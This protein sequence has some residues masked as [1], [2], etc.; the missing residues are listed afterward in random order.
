MRP[1]RKAGP[2]DQQLRLRILTSDCWP[3]G[4]DQL[5][6]T[7]PETGRNL[8]LR[9]GPYGPYLQL[10]AAA[11]GSEKARN[12][13]LPPAAAT[14]GMTLQVRR[15]QARVIKGAKWSCNYPT[16]VGAGLVMGA[17]QRGHAS[18]CRQHGDAPQGS[19]LRQTLCLPAD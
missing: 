14:S 16:A 9:M 2:N 3:T 19:I 17:V 5:L 4:G 10:E 15:L 6:G 18:G 8:R 1:R 11:D 7:D 13:A 12:V